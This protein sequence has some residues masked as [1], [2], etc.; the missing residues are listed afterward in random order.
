MMLC[1]PVS[2]ARYQVP[3]CRF[4]P[5]NHLCSGA[6]LRAVLQINVSTLFVGKLFYHDGAVHGCFYD[7]FFALMKNLFSLCHR[8]RK[9]QVYDH[10]WCTFNGFKG[11]LDNVFS[12][13][14]KHL[15]GDVFRDHVLLN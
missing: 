3:R 9:I 15:N 10:V 1:A 11:F 7:F 2:A 5:H 14:G 13:L 6:A 12:C 4:P 8:S